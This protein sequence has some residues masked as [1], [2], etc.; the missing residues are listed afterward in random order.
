[1]NTKAITVR[2]KFGDFTVS[3]KLAHDTCG[4]EELVWVLDTVRYVIA[5]IYHALAHYRHKNNK[6]AF[7]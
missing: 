3:H 4:K 2:L 5:S 6:N 7:H 1:M